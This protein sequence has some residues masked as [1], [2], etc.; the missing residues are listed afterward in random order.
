[1][2]G[3][4]FGR[5]MIKHFNIFGKVLVKKVIGDKKNLDKKTHQHYYKH[6]ASKADRKGCYT[7]P[8]QII[9][10]ST[11]LDSLWQQRDKIAHKPMRLIWGMKDIAFREDILQHWQKYFA[12][13]KT[14]QLD[15]VGHYPQEEATATVVEELRNKTDVAL[16]NTQ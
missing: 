10:S 14:I 16:V 11:W 3:E 5:F 8:K 6:L 9:A 12:Q 1:M 2:M 4:A 15:K 7:F 13:A